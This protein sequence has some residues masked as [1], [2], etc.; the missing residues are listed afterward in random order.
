[1]LASVEVEFNLAV[2]IIAADVKFSVLMIGAISESIVAWLKKE[3]PFTLIPP[4]T[5]TAWT[6][7]CPPD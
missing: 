2:V 3:S 6:P 5:L 7:S 1:V 4:V